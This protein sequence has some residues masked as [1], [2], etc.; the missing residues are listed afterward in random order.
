MEHRA[1][2]VDVS[3]LFDALLEILPRLT[4]TFMKQRR[5]VKQATV[6]GGL[7]A[8]LLVV[9]GDDDELPQ[10]VMNELELIC[11]VGAAAP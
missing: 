6:L 8:Y 7:S 1:G 11:T 4:R 2:Y 9:Q 10:D 3:K 5:Y